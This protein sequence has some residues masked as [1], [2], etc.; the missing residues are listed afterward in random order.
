MQENRHY[1]ITTLDVNVWR[2]SE[3]AKTA[4][5]SDSL[6][7]FYSTETYVVRWH[8]SVMQVGRDLKGN[9]SKH[10]GVIGRP[11]T[12]YFFWH[13]K[14][15]KATEQGSSALLTIELDEE[16]APQVGVLFVN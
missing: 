15:S 10:G 3:F 4:I 9:Q 7:H 14:D 8:Y 5:D 13:G 11:R 16:K 1:T 12:A 6:G 2:I